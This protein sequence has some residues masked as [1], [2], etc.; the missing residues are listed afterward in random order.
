MTMKRYQGFTLIELILSLAINSIII[1]SLLSILK[2]NVASYKLGEIEDE[3]ILNGRYVIEYI[4]REIRS[5]D[6]IMSIDKFD[7]LD[8]LYKDNIGFVIMHYYPSET[9]KYNYSTYYLKDNKIYRIAVNRVDSRL[10]IGS[11]FKGHNEIAEYIISIEGTNVD[12]DKK[13]IDISLTLGDRKG[14]DMKLKSKLKIRCP[15][16]Y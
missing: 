1:L 5:A 11:Y 8:E 6:K 12:F 15:I 3:I 10:P 2:F 9:Y 16:V 14:K 13:V 4:K 7:S